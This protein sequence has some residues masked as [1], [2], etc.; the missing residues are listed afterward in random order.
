MVKPTKEKQKE[1]SARWY[2]NNKELQYQRTQENYKAKRQFI[3]DYKTNVGCS[4][5]E[6][7][8]ACLDLHHI[9]PTQKEIN[10]SEMA[11]MGWS[12]K[13]IQAELD[14]CEVLCSNCHKKLHWDKRNMLD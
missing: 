3:T 8:P 11:K 5:G 4:C 10:P 13:R 14:K 12:L 7:H 6:K 2:Q 9:D 1:Y